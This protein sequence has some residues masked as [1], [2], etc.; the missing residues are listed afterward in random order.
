MEEAARE[1]GDWKPRI[2]ASVEDLRVEVEA[3]RKTVNRVVL[4]SDH[5][6]AAG[7]FTAPGSGSAAASPSA[8]NPVDGSKEHRVDLHHRESAYGA[9]YTHTHS[10]VKGMHSDPLP[11]LPRSSSHSQ[12]HSA[13]VHHNG[14]SVS[15]GTSRSC[16]RLP[17]MQFPLF[18]G[19]NPKLWIRRSE[20]Y[21]DMFQVESHMWIKVASMHFATGP[22]RWLQ[23]VERRLKSASW[24]ELCQM[25]LDRFGKS[26]HELLIRQLFHIKQL[27]SVAD[28]SE[29]FSELVYQLT[30][31]ET[32]T[33]PLYY[34]MR[35][36]DGLKATIRSAVL[37]QRPP[38]LDTA[39]V[40]ALLQEEVSDGDKRREFSKMYYSVSAKAFSKG[41]MPLP[42][43][44]KNDR[45]VHIPH[46]DDRRSA[47]AANSRSVDDK[48]A[49]LH[50]Y[51]RAKGLCVKC[52]EK[53]S[54][55]HK[56]P[57]AVQ[58]HVLQ[59]FYDL[60]QIEEDS[61]AQGDNA[62]VHSEQLFMALSMAASSGLAAPE[63]MKFSGTIQGKNVLILLDS[64]SSHTFVSAELAA[65]LQGVSSLAQSVRVQL[66]DDE[67][68]LCTSQL[69]HAAWTVQGC[70]FYSDMKILPLSSYDLIVGMDWLEQFSPM[71]IH[72]QQK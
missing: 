20:D 32:H 35:F 29:R 64:G 1:F 41:P 43:P 37:M 33:D 17:K 26:H 59:E 21:F 30:A 7:I 48:L 39:C 40:L 55:G 4:D 9:V 34:T 60:F 52:A 44:P 45:V 6:K 23:S 28:Y 50:A 38:D 12:L 58:L 14:R 24:S 36:I 61:S 25:I 71:K 66:A 22:G 10:P 49:A 15:L 5:T 63:T 18:D 47:E 69:I 42:L 65:T 2:E 31:Y 46:T 54:R 3:L 16:G 19:E 56:C 51:R 67:Q 13:D 11:V 57:E 72:W 62:S 53:W 27:T 68:L 70:T 8:G